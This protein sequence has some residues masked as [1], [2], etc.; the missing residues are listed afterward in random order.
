MQVPSVTT[1]NTFKLKIDLTDEQF[2]DVL[3]GFIL[4]MAKV[5]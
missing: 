4:D 3:P 2:L 1:T 5:M